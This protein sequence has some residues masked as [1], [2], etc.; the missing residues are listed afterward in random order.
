MEYTFEILGISPILHFF[1]QQYTLGKKTEKIGVEY[2]C[3]RRC[4]LDALI[5]SIEKVPRQNWNLD[6]VVDTVVNYWLNNADNIQYWRA[7]LHDAGNENI[8]VSRV[9]DFKSLEAE[10][11]SLLGED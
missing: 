11:E 1:N 6:R 7:R 10:F 3:T 9:A 5:A 2:L 8:L 4:T